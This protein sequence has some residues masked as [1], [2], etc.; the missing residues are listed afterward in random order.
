MN[1]PILVVSCRI[2]VKKM[3]PS[4][5]LEDVVLPQT[6]TIHPERTIKY[7]SIQPCVVLSWGCGRKDFLG[8]E[9]PSLATAYWLDSGNT[10]R[11]SL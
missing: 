9:I 6:F 5:E 4:R 8:S 2:L 7:V 10:T 1:D 11:N 3:V